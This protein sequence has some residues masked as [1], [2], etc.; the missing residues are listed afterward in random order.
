MI[1]RRHIWFGIQAIGTVVLLALLFRNF[2]W[3]RFFDVLS[4]MSPA[5]YAGSLLVVIALQLMTAIRWQMVLSALGV[6]VSF[7]E[8]L[9]QALIGMFFSNLMPTAV[10]GDAVKVY[11]LGR[12]AGYAEVG[13]SVLLDR[14]LGFLWL[15]IAGSTIAWIVPADSAL[16]QLN[17]HLLTLFAV[18]LSA[19]A[20]ASRLPIEP[21]IARVMPSRWQALQARLNEFIGLLRRGALRPA[22]MAASLVFAL[23]MSRMNAELYLRYFQAS[24]LPALPVL[25]VL[26]VMISM[27]VFVNVPL[28]VNGIGLREQL[29]VLLFA[30]L[31][32]P[33]E[34]AVWIA[35]L[36]FSHSLVLSLVGCGLWL[37]VKRDVVPATP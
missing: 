31:G 7:G 4:A 18:V 35:L 9:R 29:H 13:A 3:V 17:R 8:V 10:G 15:A 37:R 11:Y 16:L 33:P 34:V 30:G 24:G 28:S 12:T 23:V 2:D 25:P 19:L 32:V 21:V 6:T 26:L 14:F 5:F 27:S 1:N 22:P 36:L 20:F